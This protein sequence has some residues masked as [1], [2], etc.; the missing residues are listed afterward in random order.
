M[1]CECNDVFSRSFTEPDF[2]H[3]SSVGPDVYCGVGLAVG[4]LGVAAGT[5]L[6][7]KGHHGR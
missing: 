3:D 6:M 5:F 4:L 2:S 7:V 1:I